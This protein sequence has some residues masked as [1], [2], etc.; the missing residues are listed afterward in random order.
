VTARSFL[1]VGP[2]RSR[3]AA[4]VVGGVALAVLLAGCGG[5][6]QASPSSINTGGST[7]TAGRATNAGAEPGTAVGATTA[8]SAPG[9][10]GEQSVQDIQTSVND[11]QSLLDGLDRD[12]AGDAAD[13][14][15]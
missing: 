8:G 12:F 4:T 5:G 15:N 9:G 3:A 13:V 11:A 14:G 10:S 2:A 7:K 1:A 6:D